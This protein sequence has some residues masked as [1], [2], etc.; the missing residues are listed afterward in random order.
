MDINKVN[1]NRTDILLN[2]DTVLRGKK[3]IVKEIPI[4]KIDTS[5]YSF[6]YTIIKAEMK[7]PYY[8]QCMSGFSLTTIKRTDYYYIEVN[9]ANIYFYDYSKCYG[10]FEY[11]GVRFICDSIC[12]KD[13]LQKTT[14]DLSVKYL[15][16]DRSK[17]VI[18]IDDRYST[19]YFEY[20]NKKIKLTGKHLCFKPMNDNNE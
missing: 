4:Y 17:Q 19:W 1:N 5:F 8:K 18:N 16:L 2:C 14:E 15:D 13:L 7:C 10:L 11:D 6:L 9:T 12:I 20:R 3:I